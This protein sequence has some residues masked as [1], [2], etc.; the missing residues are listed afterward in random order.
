MSMVGV[1][2]NSPY[3]GGLTTQVGARVGNY[4]VP[5]NSHWKNRI[6]SHNHTV[7]MILI[8]LLLLLS[9]LS[10]VS[11]VYGYRKLT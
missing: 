11:L 3:T 10:V 7:L 2:D 1:D 6:N 8:L 4:L 9:A 5:F